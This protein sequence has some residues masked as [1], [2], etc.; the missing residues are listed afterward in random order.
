MKVERMRLG[1]FAAISATLS[2]LCFPNVTRA[3]TRTFGPFSV[4]LERPDTIHLSGAISDGAALDFRRALH[5]APNP[6]L[7]ILDS[8][9]G[10]IQ[11]ALLIADDVFV[12]KIATLVPAEAEC[13]SACAYIF[14]AGSDRQVEGKLGVHQ[15]S[16][17]AGPIGNI[18]SAQLAISDIIDVLARFNTPVEIL[19][20]MFKTP[21]DEMYIFPPEEIARLGLNRR[22]GDPPSSSPAIA[23]PR[24]PG[25][26]PAEPG[27]TKPSVPSPLRQVEKDVEKPATPPPSRGGELSSLD[28]Y[29]QSP[30]RFAVYL[31]LDLF[32]GDVWSGYAPSIAKCASECLSQASVCKAFTYNANP[33]PGRANC[34]LKDGNGIA[35]G[36]SVAVTGML[37]RRADGKPPVHSVGVI[38]ARDDLIGDIDLPGYD[39]S[40]RPSAARTAQACRL[41]CVSNSRC[42]AFTFVTRLR[43]CWLKGYAGMMRPMPGVVSGLKKHRIFKADRV[44]A[45]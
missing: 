25:G 2:I 7:L 1:L 32:G 8:S 39:L 14:L 24:D 37:L 38:D 40:P 44:I 33:L 13:Y 18:K 5:A 34:Y 31:G 35:D 11:Q 27:E 16:A 22:V 6:N 30:N 43:Q 36:N 10:N 21:S 41:A 12:R 28:R 29:I 17:G 9:G 4:D 19:T 42:E 23:S 45:L 3:E 20:R 15:I 26:D